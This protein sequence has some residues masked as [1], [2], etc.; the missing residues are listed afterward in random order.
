[1]KRFYRS[2][3][4]RTYQEVFQATPDDVEFDALINY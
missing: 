3:F 2:K 1:M 4:F